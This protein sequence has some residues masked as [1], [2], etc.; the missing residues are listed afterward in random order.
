MCIRD[1]PSD[2]VQALLNQASQALKNKQAALSEGDWAAYGA[3]D[4]LLA[5]II[6]Q[7]LAITQDQ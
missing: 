3:A 6:A 5:E 1:R 4:A 7:L 2:E